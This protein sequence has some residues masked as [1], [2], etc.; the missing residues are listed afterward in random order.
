MVQQIAGVFLLCDRSDLGI[1]ERVRDPHF[2]TPALYIYDRYPGGT[3]LA[4]ALA[5]R[6]GALLRSVKTA[7]AACP[8]RKG[9]PSCVGPDRNK[10]KTAGGLEGIAS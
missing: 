10:A 5:K 3:G 9:C 7:L 8:C 4:E 1:A 6:T 2:D